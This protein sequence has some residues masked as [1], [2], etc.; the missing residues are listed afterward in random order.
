MSLFLQAIE[1]IAWLFRK[2]DVTGT[3]RIS[4]TFDNQADEARFLRE[5]NRD[6]NNVIAFQHNSIGKYSEFT[7]YGVN[8]RIL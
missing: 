7:I 8:V 2:A 6:I 4:I 3:P 1:K 5:L